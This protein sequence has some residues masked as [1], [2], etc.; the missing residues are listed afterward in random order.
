M[1]GSAAFSNLFQTFTFTPS[2]NLPTGQTIRVRLKNTIKDTCGQPLQTPANGISLFS[3]TTIPP[4]TIPPAVPVVNP[5]PA[6]TNQV[7][8]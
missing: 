6:L 2:G 8:I 7:L 1:P 3:F 4:D 5:V